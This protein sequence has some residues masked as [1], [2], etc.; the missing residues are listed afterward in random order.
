MCKF[1]GLTFS[2]PK[3]QVFQEKWD[4]NTEK[5]EVFECKIVNN[6]SF[7]ATRSLIELFSEN[8]VM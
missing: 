5:N 3:M 4:Y 8:F 6:F 2:Y 1:W 7:C